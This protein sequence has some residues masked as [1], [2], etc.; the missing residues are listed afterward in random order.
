MD[1][2]IAVLVRMGGVGV[3][4]WRMGRLPA[5]RALSQCKECRLFQ[6]GVWF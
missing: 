3:C 4:V 5:V 2:G 6:P 1:K